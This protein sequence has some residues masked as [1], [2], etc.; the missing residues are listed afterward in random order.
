[1]HLLVGIG[2]S[3]EGRTRRFSATFHRL[4][5]L[6]H[7]YP[8]LDKIP[9]KLTQVRNVRDLRYLKSINIIIIFCANSRLS[10]ERA[11]RAQI[12]DDKINRS[13]ACTA[14]NSRFPT[15]AAD[16]IRLCVTGSQW[17]IIVFLMQANDSSYVARFRDKTF[18]KFRN[19][20]KFSIKTLRH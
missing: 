2:W 12:I 4:K 5:C 19:V 20:S 10:V 9:R 14:P 15:F 6:P 17:Y 11:N 7:K 8:I 16:S 1:M 18:S 13:F 3:P